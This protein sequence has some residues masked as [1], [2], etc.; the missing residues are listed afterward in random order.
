MVKFLEKWKTLGRVG[1]NS[2]FKMLIIFVKAFT[3]AD[4][5]VFCQKSTVFGTDGKSKGLHKFM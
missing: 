4:I 1:T 5:I 2:Y 3:N